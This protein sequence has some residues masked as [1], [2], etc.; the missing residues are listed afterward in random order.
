MQHGT[1]LLRVLLDEITIYRTEIKKSIEFYKDQLLEYEDLLAKDHEFVDTFEQ[2][3]VR[4]AKRS[5]HELQGKD[6]G[7]KTVVKRLNELI[8]S[9]KEK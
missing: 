8:E 6:E 9:N 3:M 1:I 5:L 2:Y 7:Y 4:S